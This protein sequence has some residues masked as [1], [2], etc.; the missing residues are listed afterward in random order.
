MVKATTPT[1]V[2]PPVAGGLS[3]LGPSVA[4]ALSGIEQY[5]EERSF[6]GWDPYDALNSPVLRT[7]SLGLKYPRIAVTQALKRLPVNL[8]PALFVKPSRNPKGLG[9]FLAG[10]V[11]RYRATGDEAHARRAHALAAMLEELRSPGTKHACWGYPF[12][13]QSRAFFVPR[14]TPTIVNTSFVGHALIDAAETFREERYLRLAR[15]ACDFI[16]NDLHRATDQEAICF[17]YTPIDQ[18]RVHNANMLGAGLLAR[19]GAL[20]KE[21]E[22]LDTAQRATR[23]L[24]RY[25]HEDGGWWY[26]EPEYQHWIDSFH[27]GFNLVAL[28]HVVRDAGM[29]EA[30]EALEKGLVFFLRHFY[31]RDGTPKY[32]H[33]KTDPIDVHCPAQG[34]VTMT[35]LYD[36]APAPELMDRSTRWFL[37]NMRSP[38]G[39]FYYRVGKR[40]PNRIPYLRWG[41][42]WAYFGLAHLEEFLARSA[43]S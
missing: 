30:V 24:L 14:W 10:S 19:V 31:E 17:S 39:Y 23:Y 13:W 25:Q 12:P 5:A 7:V 2:T 38:E 37:A 26:A 11:R 8:R 3:T 43:D 22:L 42:A 40:G 29:T 28:R 20:T 33:D 41:Q 35:D 4:D 15:S 32:Y 6:A 1:H 34:L 18:L 9:L 16:L 21:S 27:T 36:V